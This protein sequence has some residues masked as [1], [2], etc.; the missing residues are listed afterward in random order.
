MS[1]IITHALAVMLGMVIGAACCQPWIKYLERELA[2]L[3]R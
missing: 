2:R 3:G 1:S